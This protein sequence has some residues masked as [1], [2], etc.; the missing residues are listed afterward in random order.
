MLKTVQKIYFDCCKKS[1]FE[2]E[3][4]NKKKEEIDKIK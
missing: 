1:K 3:I 2:V 4:D